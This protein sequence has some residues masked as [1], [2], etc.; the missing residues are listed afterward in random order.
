MLCFY[1]VARNFNAPPPPL[2]LIQS[3]PRDVFLNYIQVMNHS[4]ETIASVLYES[5][6]SNVDP[7]VKNLEAVAAPDPRAD[8]LRKRLIELLAKVTTQAV[9]SPSPSPTVGPRRG[10]KLDEKVIKEFESW[11][12]DYNAWLKTAVQNLNQ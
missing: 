11:Q 10:S 2:V 9:A 8:E 12:N 5:D 4:H 1:K 7:T 3:T 6:V